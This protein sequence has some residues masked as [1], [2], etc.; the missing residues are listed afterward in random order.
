MEFGAKL[1]LS[2][3]KV[4]KT[5][6]PLSREGASGQAEDIVKH[7]ALTEISRTSLMP[8]T[9]NREELF[10]YQNEIINFVLNEILD[11]QISYSCRFWIY[12]KKK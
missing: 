5:H 12:M 9:N 7:L 11:M 4:L 3:R 1:D 6:R 10:A 2:C 8:A